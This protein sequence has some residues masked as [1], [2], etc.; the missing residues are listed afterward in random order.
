MSCWE[1][2]LNSERRKPKPDKAQKTGES[3]STDART[4]IERDYDRILFST[5]VRRLADKT[6]VFPLERNDS[7]RTRLTHSYEVSNLAR[8]LGVILAF[9]DKIITDEA[10]KSER[11]LPAIL[12]AIGLA[13]DL[14]NPPFGHQGEQAIQAWF[15]DNPDVLKDSELN[16]AMKQDFIKFEGNAQTLRLLTRLQLID[17][18]YGLNLTYATLAALMKYPTASDKIDKN[19]V[20]KKKHGYFQSEKEIVAEVWGK[21][22]LSDGV[23]HPLTYVME[24]CDDIAYAVVDA[25]DAVKKGLVSFSDLMSYLEHHGNGDEVAGKVVKDACDRHKKYRAESGLSP[26]ELND[27][28]MQK[29]RVDA[30][31]VMIRDVRDAYEN[32]KDKIMDGSLASDLLTVSRSSKLCELLK[33]FDKEHAYVHRSVLEVELTGYNTIRGLMDFLWGAI[34]QRT[35]PEILSSRRST[36]FA[37]YA[38]NRISENYRRIFENKD[39]DDENPLPVRYK[40]CQLLTDMISGMTDSFALSL[41]DELKQYYVPR[42]S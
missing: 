11:N 38:Y 9:D 22:G 6:Q 34:H 32:Q 10:L 41:Y 31:G 12:A 1:Q 21:T 15:A 36:P 42:E 24:A 3:K 8:S 7:V 18:E 27:I 37:S 33:K 30:I 25:E 4:E 16:E 13:H 19:H 14:G 28:S 2:L 23:R 5:P 40:E 39:E 17:G 20:A 26:A 29:F 35:K